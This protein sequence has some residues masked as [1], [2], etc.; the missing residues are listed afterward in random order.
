MSLYIGNNPQTSRATMHLTSSTD[1]LTTLLG[2]PT[3]NTLFHS[4][5]PYLAIQRRF[6]ITRFRRFRDYRLSNGT[7]VYYRPE[8]PSALQSLIDQGF[9]ISMS[10]VSMTSDGRFST[11]PVG[12]AQDLGVRAKAVLANGTLG[13]DNQLAASGQ[14]FNIYPAFYVGQ[15]SSTYV[16]VPVGVGAVNTAVGVPGSNGFWE[17]TPGMSRGS[18]SLSGFTTADS[19]AYSPTFSNGGSTVTSANYRSRDFDDVIGTGLDSRGGVY[20]ILR[21]YDDGE[22]IPTTIDGGI[23]SDGSTRNFNLNVWVLNVRNDSNGILQHVKPT[24]ENNQVRIDQDDLQVGNLSVKGG[25]FVT[26]ENPEIT[27][28]RHSSAGS[29]KKS[30]FQ[31]LFN[32][33]SREELIAYPFLNARVT[34]EANGNWQVTGASQSGSFAT[35]SNRSLMQVI[36]PNLQ[37]GG[38]VTLQFSQDQIRY[39]GNRGELFLANR[40]TNFT[41]LR[42]GG[43]DAV[44]VNFPSR[45]MKFQQ[46]V[47][48]ASFRRLPQ[49]ST[50]TFLEPDSGWH[51]R[52]EVLARVPLPPGSTSANHLTMHVSPF[53]T[54]GMLRV[55]HEGRQSRVNLNVQPERGVPLLNLR[56][57]NRSQPDLSYEVARVAMAVFDDMRL[58]RRGSSRDG[59]RMF[60]STQNRIQ[61]VEVRYSYRVDWGGNHIELVADYVLAG[62]NRV[63]FID[64]QDGTREYFNRIGDRE[65][66]YTLP[67]VDFNMYVL[68]A[69]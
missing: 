12:V 45:T 48:G 64:F 43:E 34:R 42:L 21:Y 57:F 24:E 9:L 5:I 11:N 44:N 3:A 18:T 65:V 1:N 19:V 62:R 49:P 31:N 50:I 33:L 4:D 37:L 39:S 61:S 2:G 54:S 20:E 38:T 8:I 59:Y 58:E 41:P 40:N 6:F 53:K 46:L 60:S 66:D 17:S 13:P 10:I 16:P 27:D 7:R 23:N 47:Q 26:D 35:T 32:N 67:E 25:M 14:Y 30:F 36:A 29:T 56:R 69:G 55:L 68:N 52:T 22:T 15:P 51:V 28:I 63:E